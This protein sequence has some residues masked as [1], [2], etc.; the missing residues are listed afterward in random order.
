LSFIADITPAEYAIALFGAF[1]M[2]FSKTGFPGLAMVNVLLM[3]EIFGAKKSLGLI[4][5]LLVV[6]DL[7]VYP[8]F[9]KYAS[10]RAVWPLMIPALAGVFIGYFLLKDISDL[11]ARRTIGGIILFML[12]LQA[13]RTYHQNFLQH[14]PDSKFF[15]V[16][17][18]LTIGISTMMA[19][20]A[21]S[22]YSIY[23][24][25]HRM[26]KMNFLGIGARFFLFINIFN[27]PF[28][29]NLDIINPW[30]LK[31]GLTLLPGIFVGIL[32]G[33][34][35]VTKIPQRVFEIL[36]YAFS[37]IAGVRLLFF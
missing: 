11:T 25:V 26:E 33:K 2:G 30:S 35:L 13:L 29:A 17:S 18:G 27:F 3:A 34:R 8:L 32:L 16:G 9:R 6:C 1:C 5:P 31:I 4:L 12:A 22:V 23:A 20:A 14:L 21:G 28:M 37:L 19:N 36:L 10:W 24:L 15:L 7:L